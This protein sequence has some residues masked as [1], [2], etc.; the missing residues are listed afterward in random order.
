MRDPRK[1]AQ[2]LETFL[3]HEVQAA[4]LMAWAIL[5]FPDAP[6]AMRRGLL[7]ILGD[8]LRHVAMY[9]ERIAALGGA[10]WGS[11]PPNDWFWQRVPQ[12]ASAAAFTATLGIGF[13]GGNLDHAARFA[14]RLRAAG[15]AEAAAIQER[16]GEEEIPHVRFAL[17]WFREL[18][19]GP[20]DFDAWRAHLPVPLT[21]TVARGQPLN[22]RDRARAGFDD[23]FLA[24]LAAWSPGS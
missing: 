14:E 22:T 8:E 7:G 4:E 23:A 3:H 13:E 5:A 2:L 15:D 19:G 17:H 9:G 21:P 11:E 24:R 1:R 12:V 18:T 6:Q 10:P 20:I 16:V